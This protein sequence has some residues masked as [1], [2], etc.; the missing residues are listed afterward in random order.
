MEVA[1]AKDKHEQIRDRAHQ[2]WEDEGMPD[3]GDVRHWLQAV[4]ELAGDDDHETMQEMIDR[5]DYADDAAVKSVENVL[6]DVRSRPARSPQN[7]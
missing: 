6:P 1:M 7:R 5:D 2:I 4:D 3:G